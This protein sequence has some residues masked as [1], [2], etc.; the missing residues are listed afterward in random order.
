MKLLTGDTELISGCLEATRYNLDES[1][2]LYPLGL[3]IDTRSRFGAH[4][5]IDMEM[6]GRPLQSHFEADRDINELRSKG[7]YQAALEKAAAR[8]LDQNAAKEAV[9]EIPIAL[10]VAN[11]LSWEGTLRD[12]AAKVDDYYR[13]NL[14][15]IIAL[16]RQCEAKLT[17]GDHPVVIIEPNQTA[18]LVV[19]SDLCTGPR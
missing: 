10:G 16:F 2:E 17:F 5:A 19:Q 6:A 14:E 8:V 12:Y 7:T 3:I 18:Y 15:A 4:L 11:R 13:E 9:G 1:D